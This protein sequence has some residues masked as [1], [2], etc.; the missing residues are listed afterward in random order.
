MS[1]DRTPTTS[2]LREGSPS[3]DDGIG[4]RGPDPA[5]RVWARRRR[6]RGA[7]VDQVDKNISM[8]ANVSNGEVQRL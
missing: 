8:E 5:D 3:S 2:R 6:R 4:A 1:A 7:G